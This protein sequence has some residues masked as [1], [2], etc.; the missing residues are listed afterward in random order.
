LAERLNAD[1]GQVEQM[2]G[3]HRAY[4]LADEASG[5][6][7]IVAIWETEDALDASAETAHSLREQAARDAGGSVDSVENYR[8]I[9]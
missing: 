3:L 6:V 8:V 5:K 1:R 2:E 7:M 9:E 4:L